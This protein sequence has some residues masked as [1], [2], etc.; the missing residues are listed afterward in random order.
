MADTGICR[1]AT[2][3]TARTGIR[4]IPRRCLLLAMIGDGGREGDNGGVTAVGGSLEQAVHRE[5]DPVQGVVSVPV[6]T[7]PRVNVERAVPGGGAGGGRGRAV[8]A[9]LHGGGERG[10]TGA[11]RHPGTRGRHAAGTTYTGMRAIPGLSSCTSVK[12]L[13]LQSTASAWRGV[14]QPHHILPAAWDAGQLPGGGN[15]THTPGSS[16]VTPGGSVAASTRPMRW[17]PGGRWGAAGAR[18]PGRDR[19]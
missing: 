17:A 2:G 9:L 5:V 14:W 4:H 10:H 6:R 7:A 19:A 12:W 1:A 8:A 13:Q 11:A 3:G 18:T 15:V 16:T